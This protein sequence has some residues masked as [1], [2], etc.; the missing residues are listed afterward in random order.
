MTEFITKEEAEKI[1]KEAKMYCDEESQYQFEKYLSDNFHKAINLAFEQRLEV[2]GWEVK[3]E[4]DQL[5]WRYA[6]SFAVIQGKINEG[7]WP[8]IQYRPLYALKG[9]SK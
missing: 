3:Y 6:S 7:L 2:V 5:T 1:A 9:D 8:D 4:K